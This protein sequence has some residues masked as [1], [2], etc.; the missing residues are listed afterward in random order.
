M[1][2]PPNVSPEVFSVALQAFAGVVGKE[3]V[4]VE[5]EDLFPYRDSY[6][7]LRD[8]PEDRSASAAVAPGSVEE[9]QAVVRIADKHR[10]PL[11]TIS[12][13][14]NLGYGGSAP[15]HGGSVVLDL[16]RMNRII[17]VN[18]SN[19]YAIVEPGVSYFDLYN[20]I[21]ERGLKVWLDVADPGW[22]SV[23][24]NALDHGV[25]HTLSRFRNHFDSHCG[26]EVVLANGE[27]VRTG[28]GALPGSQTWGQFKMGMGPILDG[29]FSQS[30]FG[31][32][33]KMGIWLMPAPEAFMHGM[34]MAAR[35]DDLHA[36]VELLKY[37]ENTGLASGAPEMGSPLLGISNYT[38][39]LV[40]AFY[41]GPPQLQ[42]QHADLI[43]KASVGYSAE[44]Q[45]YGLDNNIPYWVLNL[46]FYGPPKVIQAQ[47]EAVQELAE[48]SIKGVRFQAGQIQSD[49]RKASAEWTVYPQD[50]GVPNMDFFGMGTRAGGNPH[51]MRGH[52]WFSPVI[53][54]TA[55]GILEANRVFEEA[56]RTLPAL[57]NVPIWNLRPFALPAPFFERAFLFIVGFPI[58]DDASMNKASIKAYRTLLD[59]GAQHGWGEY[60]CHP[61][62]QD[63][64]MGLYSYNNNSLL[65]LNEVIKDAIDPNGILSPGRYGIWPRH[66]RKGAQ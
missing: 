39:H 12:T 19:G 64:A 27:M 21:Q 36:V 53:P 40:D 41:E 22:G 46:K 43:A 24:G 55:Q 5:D 45:K 50:V 20:Y 32:V 26:M 4:F 59:I 63:Q 9:V 34:V 66:L 57:Q 29:I 58:T 33:T 6:S 16:K 2:T 60:R 28:M 49:P 31:V 15:N 42:K 47:W 54:Q 17:E 25:G 3:W 35:Y 48:K 14:K 51:P 7:P 10:I 37:V 8:T 44:L 52:M 38:K 65:R 11:Y 18:E 13:G 23:V 56:Y 62:F 61:E 1:R 30:N